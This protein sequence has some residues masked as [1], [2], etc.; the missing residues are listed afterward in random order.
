MN[1]LIYILLI[2]AITSCDEALFNAGDIETKSI[3]VSSFKEIYIDDIFE[4]YLIQDTTCNIEA[5]GGNNLL[6]DLEFTVDEEKKLTISDNNSARWSRDYN[7]IEL[8]ISVDTLNYLRLNAPCNVI[9]VN[10]LTTLNFKIW[11]IT[12]FAEFDLT[13]D[14]ENFYFVNNN[15]SGGI[16]FVQGVTANL[17]FWARGS[18]I[19]NAENLIADQVTVKN[20]SMADCRVYANDYLSVE[21]LRAG[22][23][24]Y[25]GNPTTIEYV[26][27]KAKEQLI[28]LD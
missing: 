21:I 19:V 13:L 12:D 24:F 11:S 17:N 20:E 14:C 10:T 5:K 23:V 27:D 22:R 1:K 6:S 18:F 16:M 28:K 3:E 4:V 25:K 26:N 15:T 9:S 7:K 2:L 8:Y